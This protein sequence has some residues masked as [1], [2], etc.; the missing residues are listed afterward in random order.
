MI[1]N[2]GGTLCRDD[3]LIEMDTK[4]MDPNFDSLSAKILKR[5]TTE[6]IARDKVLAIEFL[7]RLDRTRYSC[8]L[9]SLEN[10]FSL[11]MD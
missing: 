10:I 9:D 1:E 8:L 7:E 5:F 3:D 2:H 6:S 4:K 11:G